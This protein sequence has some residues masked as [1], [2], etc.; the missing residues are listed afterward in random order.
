MSVMPAVD[1]I[2]AY[3]AGDMNDEEMVEFFQELIDSGMA[4]KLQ[5]HY[6]RTAAALLKAGLCH[7]K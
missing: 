7:K 1:K 6:S 2:M 5:G 3:E 4:W